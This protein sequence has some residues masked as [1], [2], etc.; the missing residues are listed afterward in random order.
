MIGRLRHRLVLEAPVR[1]PDGGGGAQ[2]S[3]QTVAT[4]WT[5]LDMPSGA[6]HARGD[7]REAL[8]QVRIRLRYRSG[9]TP[10]H[11]FRQGA[12]VF[13]IR[14]VLDETGTGRWLTCLC[15]EGGGT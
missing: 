2:V 6:E 11:R 8:R 5:S 1:T 9:L 13:A 4:L 12:R 10:A 3:W 15:D 7:R 14:A